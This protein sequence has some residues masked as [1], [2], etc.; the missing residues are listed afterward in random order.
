MTVKHKRKKPYLLRRVLHI[1]NLITRFFFRTIGYMLGL[2]IKTLTFFCLLMVVLAAVS[3]FAFIKYF[4]S[5]EIAQALVNQLTAALGRPVAVGSIELKFFNYAKI[6]DLIVFDSGENGDKILE[7]SSVML[8][9]NPL[10]ILDRRL[11]I[12]QVSLESPRIVLTRAADGTV[13]IPQ[14]KIPQRSAKPD[15]SG[16]TP[17]VVTVNDWEIKDGTFIFR[18]LGR[19]TSYAF[20]NVDAGFTGL[21]FNN[22]SPFNLSFAFRNTWKDK[23]AEA[24]VE[25]NGR[26]NFAGFDGNKF[27]L[28]NVNAAVNF[29]KKPVTLNFNMDNINTPFFSFTAN[30]PAVNDAD[31]SL[32]LDKP[33]GVNFPQ[34]KI[35]ASTVLKNS[36]TQL[37]VNKLAV[38]AGDVKL[39]GSGNLNFDKEQPY[40]D[41]NFKTE[42]FALDG[43][44]KIY[45]PIK[46]YGFSGSAAISANGSF[47]GNVLKLTNISAQL[48]NA[49]AKFGA[50]NGGFNIS[51]ADGAVYAKDDFNVLGA[52]LTNGELKLGKQDFTG[53]A[54]TC[55]YSRPKN[56]L[57]GFVTS[58]KLNGVP[59]KISTDIINFNNNKTRAIT[60][61]LYMQNF[62]VMPF[63]D[64]IYDF[65]MAIVKPS[66]ASAAQQDKDTGNLAWLHFFKSGIP[67][68]MPN[69][70]G[71][72]AA[73][74][75]SSPVLSGKNFYAEFDLTGLLPGLETLTG[76]LDSQMENGVIYQLE[77]KADTE[78]VL[79]IAFQP[80]I[81][82]HRMEK[83][84]SFKVGEVLRDVGYNKIALSTNYKNGN[85]DIVNFYC[86]GKTLGVAARGGV[87]WDYETLDV[88]FWTIFKNIS[89]S[90]ALAEN[91]T[92]ASG[93]PALSF[94]VKDR[95]SAPNVEM[96]KPATS[97][98]EINK[99]IKK[100]LR[101]D[102]ANARNFKPGTNNAPQQP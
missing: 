51:G 4:N 25:A 2:T 89:R 20:Y 52:K 48:K 37:A 60:T 78:K 41:F 79:G 74:V 71:L 56:T 12:E 86:D 85:M 18:D 13:N 36:N 14:I 93:A 59:M 90:G 101:T 34:M 95:M 10:P 88:T 69:F 57:N 67:K 9:Y 81:V 29:F 49:A 63:Y 83:A 80:F 87:D 22:P 32:F 43:K 6:N 73:D 35:A 46:K 38:V 27:N 50:L 61:N 16:K 33:L 65:V 8:R 84:G 75:F 58:A 11:S 28:R 39:S 40:G 98:D 31:L 102:F 5:Q 24:G 96:L 68:F 53:V 44:E 15:A 64:T 26:I 82:M 23:M 77:K 97:G 19:N 54:G 42:M 55:E 70:K 99:A 72:I 66:P 47:A 62:D 45:A 94:R 100:A 30:L 76:T 91:L 21:D 1:I 92:D 17:F 3:W 7:A